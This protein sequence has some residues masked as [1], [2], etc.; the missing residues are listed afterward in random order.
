MAR[1]RRELGVDLTPL[2]DVILILLFL[3]LVCSGHAA[4]RREAEREREEAARAAAHAAELAAREAGHEEALLL[5]E[6]RLDTEIGARVQAEQ[7]AESLERERRYLAEDLAELEARSGID[8]ES[9][10]R[11]ALFDRNSDRLDLTVPR[12]YPDEPLVLELNGRPHGRQPE[13]ISLADWLEPVIADL[14]QRIVVLTLHYDNEAIYWRDYQQL[15]RSLLELRAASS[16]LIL[17]NE[18]N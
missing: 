3:V 1:R 10:E 14:E 18:R 12:A 15:H 4:G 5:I 13:D 11:Y 2:L 17:Y 8:R 6:N 9:S 16:Q 7:K